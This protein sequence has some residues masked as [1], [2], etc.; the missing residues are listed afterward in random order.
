MDG[1]GTYQPDPRLSRLLSDNSVSRQR[2]NSVSHYP[3][4]PHHRNLKR[5]EPLRYRWFA[6]SYVERS[7]ELPYMTQCRHPLMQQ[8]L[9]DFACPACRW[10]RH[11]KFR[12]GIQNV[13]IHSR[14]LDRAHHRRSLH[15]VAKRP[16][17]QPVRVHL[18]NRTVFDGAG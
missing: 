12:I 6:R 14:R 16:G 5:S 7:A 13:C 15:T 10:P 2:S 11:N 17:V 8:Q 9:V 3:H 4:R 1:I 18:H